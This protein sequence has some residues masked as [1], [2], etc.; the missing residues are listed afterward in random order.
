[1]DVKFSL[2]LLSSSSIRLLFVIPFEITAIE[3]LVE[4]DDRKIVECA[5]TSRVWIK[6]KGVRNILSMR[7]EDLRLENSRIIL[8]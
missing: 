5:V 1:M 3:S 2:P 6:E 7:L 4:V 8:D